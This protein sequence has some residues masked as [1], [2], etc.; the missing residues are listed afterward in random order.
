MIFN[1]SHAEPLLPLVTASPVKRLSTYLVK[2]LALG[3]LLL[4]LVFCVLSAYVSIHKKDLLLA[5]T[6]SLQQRISGNVRIEDLSVSLLNNFPYLSIK[7]KKVSVVDSL[8]ALHQRKLFSA[9]YVF[10]RINPIRLLV[11]SLVVNKIEIRKGT[12]YLLTNE[13]GYS[14]RYLMHLKEPDKANKPFNLHL[15]DLTLTHVDLILDDQLHQKYYS[16]TIQSLRLKTGASTGS[17]V[18]SWMESRALVHSPTPKGKQP[19]HPAPLVHGQ[20]TL[21]YEKPSGRLW[22]TEIN[23]SLAG[24]PVHLTGRYAPEEALARLVQRIP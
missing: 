4:L 16:I 7:L 2:A 3:F 24:N 21:L 8:Y 19:P 22:F 6:N 15:K 20:Y 1:T 11:Q 17:H 10:L 9:D 5:A 13:D 18:T 23:A 12:L 14:N